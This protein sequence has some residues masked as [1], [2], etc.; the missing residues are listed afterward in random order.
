[1]SLLDDL[2]RFQVEYPNT[3]VSEPVSILSAVRA[4]GL[5][6]QEEGGVAADFRPALLAVLAVA[7]GEAE[8]ELVRLCRRYKVE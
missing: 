6:P 2:A 3:D 7:T 1:V 8:S 5:L 4:T